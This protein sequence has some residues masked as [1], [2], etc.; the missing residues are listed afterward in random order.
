MAAFEE[1]SEMSA[2]SKCNSQTTDWGQLQGAYNVPV[3]TTSLATSPFLGPI[4]SAG[5]YL[6]SPR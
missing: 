6:K 1:G 5:H 2:G 4:R 3:A